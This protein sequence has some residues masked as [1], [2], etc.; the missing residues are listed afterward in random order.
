MAGIRHCTVTAEPEAAPG[1]P[2]DCRGHEALR[3]PPS[4][5]R[6]EHH[7]RGS[8]VGDA[9]PSQ[10][11]AHN[12]VTG[13]DPAAGPRR[14]PGG[15]ERQTIS[16]PLQTTWTVALSDDRSA[17][18]LLRVWL[19]N[20][21]DFRARLSGVRASTGEEEAE[22]FTVAVASSP[23]EVLVAVRTWLE[24]FIRDAGNPVDSTP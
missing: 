21:D 15:A 13:Q 18:L 2:R 24:T 1:G 7:H 10:G 14:S 17:A 20:G 11:S 3:F 5:S 12:R 16:L 23:D 22:Q 19:E 8:V 9:N 6:S 4:G